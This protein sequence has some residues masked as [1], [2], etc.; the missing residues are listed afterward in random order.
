[1]MYLFAYS[2]TSLFFE[3]KGEI[4]TVAID[5][6]T[7]TPMKLF[8]KL[9]GVRFVMNRLQAVDYFHECHNKLTV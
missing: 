3:S 6:A 7:E 2:D 1:M 5:T 9:N 4:I 8:K